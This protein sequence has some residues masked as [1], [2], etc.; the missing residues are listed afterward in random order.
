MATTRP[1]LVVG[2]DGSPDGDRALEWALTQARALGGVVHA[3][4]GSP[5]ALAVGACGGNKIAPVGTCSASGGTTS[6]QRAI[7]TSFNEGNLACADHC[8]VIDDPS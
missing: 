2:V 1:R 4:H 5:T 3:L 6:A 7:L 8:V